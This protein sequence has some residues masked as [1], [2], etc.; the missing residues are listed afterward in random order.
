MPV[1]SVA[2][3]RDVRPVGAACC[4]STGLTLRLK[5]RSLMPA[6]PPQSEQASTG[7]KLCPQLRCWSLAGKAAWRVPQRFSH[8]QII[9]TWSYRRRPALVRW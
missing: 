3:R 4:N 7:T 2:D 9:S 6:L 8:I 5:R 1:V